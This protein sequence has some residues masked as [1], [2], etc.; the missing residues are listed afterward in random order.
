MALQWR[1]SERNGVSTHQPYHCLLNSL[2]SRR[3][4]KTSKLCVTGLCVG[5]SPVTGEFPVH[6][7]SNAE[8]VFIWWRHHGRRKLSQT[9]RNGNAFL[10]LCHYVQGHHWSSLIGLACLY[11]PSQY[12]PPGAFISPTG[13]VVNHVLLPKARH[14]M[15]YPCHYRLRTRLSVISTKL[16]FAINPLRAS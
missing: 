8:N 15:T 14:G 13:G 7:A 12:R 5:N 9:A 10:G 1:H 11:P 16:Q 4:E 2:F 3:S 6:M